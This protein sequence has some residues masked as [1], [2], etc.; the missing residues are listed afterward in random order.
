MKTVPFRTTVTAF[1]AALA[2]A[3]CA[4]GPA[5]QKPTVET[6]AAFKEGQG[7]WVKA[8]PADTLERGPW[9]ELF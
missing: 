6:P 7:E 2:L 8:V 4:V 3:A 9:W 1:A 5:Y